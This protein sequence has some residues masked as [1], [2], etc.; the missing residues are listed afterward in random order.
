MKHGEL[1]KWASPPV[2]PGGKLIYILCV[3]LHRSHYPP[4]VTDAH[5]FIIIGKMV[6][7]SLFFFNVVKSLKMVYIQK[8][9]GTM[10]VRSGSQP[11]LPFVP[12]CPLCLSVERWGE[13]HS[14]MLVDTHRAAR[15]HL[16]VDA[17][18]SSV[19]KSIWPPSEQ[20]NHTEQKKQEER[21]SG[22]WIKIKC[23]FKQTQP[24]SV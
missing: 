14:D 21:K 9:N 6:I 10:S 3:I 20:D 2:L 22:K 7:C 4:F 5:V 19:F 8:N 15:Y 17:T 13:R 11:H 12:I 23:V 24:A 16:C 18:R 1:D